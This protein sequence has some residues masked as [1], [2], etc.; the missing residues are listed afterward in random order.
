MVAAEAC[1]LLGQLDPAAADI[2]AALLQPPQQGHGVADVEIFLGLVAAHVAVV[3]AQH[4]RRV[5]LVEQKETAVPVDVIGKVVAGAPCMLEAGDPGNAFLWPVLHLHAMRDGVG[6]PDRSEER[7]VGKEW[8]S[9]CR[10][11]GSP[12][13]EKKK[14]KKRDT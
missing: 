2:D 1:G 3:V 11:R 10:S 12:T 9:T 6:G 7:R 14:E 8:V 13:Y 4:R 5:A